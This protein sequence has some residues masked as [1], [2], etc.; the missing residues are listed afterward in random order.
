MND[1]EFAVDHEKAI[2]L[3]RDRV[4]K[5]GCR[6]RVVVDARYR[7]VDSRTNFRRPIWVIKDVA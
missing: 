7:R 5:R 6:Q 4:E 3:A 1:I 2:E